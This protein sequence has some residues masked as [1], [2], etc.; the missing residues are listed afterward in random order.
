MRSH[1]VLSHD[2]NLSHW[3][4]CG[5]MMNYVRRETGMVKKWSS[6]TSGLSS[7]RWGFAKCPKRTRFWT[8]IELLACIFCKIPV[9]NWVWR[10]GTDDGRTTKLERSLHNRPFGQLDYTFCKQRGPAGTW[11]LLQWHWNNGDHQSTWLLTMKPLWLQPNLMIPENN[12]T[13]G[14]HL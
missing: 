2:E 10:D 6:A 11:F 3:V 9:Q 1:D 8:R 13:G 4:T 7:I 14:I 12:R 5:V